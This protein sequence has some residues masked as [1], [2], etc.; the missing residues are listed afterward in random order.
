MLLKE[1]VIETFVPQTYRVER[2]PKR[3]ASEVLGSRLENVA[4][5]EPPLAIGIPFSSTKSL[6]RW[7]LLLGSRRSELMSCRLSLA[8][9]GAPASPE[10]T[11]R[12][13][14]LDRSGRAPFESGPPASELVA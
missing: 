9:V 7:P 6:L 10:R 8:L 14:E 3:S 11:K 2:P 5:S 1:S 13:V 4:A 12:P